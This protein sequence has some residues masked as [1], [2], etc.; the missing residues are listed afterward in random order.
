MHLFSSLCF[1]F[2]FFFFFFFSQQAERI[3]TAT[4]Y[5]HE[6]LIPSFAM[7]LLTGDIMCEINVNNLVSVCHNYGINARHLGKV[8]K[9]R[10]HV[11]SLECVLFL[12]YVMF[13]FNYFSSSCFGSRHVSIFHSLGVCDLVRDSTCGRGGRRL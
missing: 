9:V 10:G 7:R 11:T 13:I 5:L 1:F 8:R 3:L 4:R 6:Q 12:C 2:F